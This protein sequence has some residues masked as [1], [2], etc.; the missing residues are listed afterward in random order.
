MTS[1]SKSAEADRLA[2]SDR[3]ALEFERVLDRERDNVEGDEVSP[4]EEE[5]G[6]LSRSIL[7]S[8]ARSLK[9]PEEP[10]ADLE[11]IRSAKLI[12]VGNRLNERIRSSLASSSAKDLSRAAAPSRIHCA[13][14]GS[15]GKNLSLLSFFP[16][17]TY[18]SLLA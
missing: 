7:L 11:A 16:P 2:K 9:L 12:E 18:A 1:D 10:V 17:N 14:S 3:S 4:V 8:R 5:V 13:C 15:V 6:N